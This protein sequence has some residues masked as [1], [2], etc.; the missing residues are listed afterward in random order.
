MDLTDERLLFHKKAR[1]PKEKKGLKKRTPLKAHSE[2]IDIKLKK[3]VLEYRGSFCLMGFCPNC[4]GGAIVTEHDDGHHWPHRSRGGKDR[5]EDIWLMKHDCHMFLHDNPLIEKQVF[6][7]MLT[8]AREIL[9][10][11][12]RNEKPLIS[13]RL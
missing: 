8:K 2:P 5:V 11:G 3:A 6:G 13:E 7:E 4:G 12:G 9:N 10:I 1:P